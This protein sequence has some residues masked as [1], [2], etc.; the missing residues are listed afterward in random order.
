MWW[1][2]H[3]VCYRVLWMCKASSRDTSWLFCISHVVNSYFVPSAYFHLNLMPAAE[4]TQLC[5]LHCDITHK[6]NL[7]A[8][9]CFGWVGGVWSMSSLWILDWRRIHRDHL[10]WNAEIEAC[11]TQPGL[12]FGWGIY[13]SAL[14]F[15]QGLLLPYVTWTWYFRQGLSQAIR[16]LFTSASLVLEL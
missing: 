16:D 4:Y 11:T 8:L 1:C 9:W 3:S 12:G 10:S 15:R 6:E 14:C 5:R 13:V 2:T 7:K